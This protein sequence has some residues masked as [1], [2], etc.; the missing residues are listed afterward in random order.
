MGRKFTTSVRTSVTTDGFCVKS[1]KRRALGDMETVSQTV[2]GSITT[3]D[4]NVSE[5]V[6]KTLSNRKLFMDS[7]NVE[8]GKSEL[9]SEVSDIHQVKTTEVI[10]HHPYPNELLE[11]ENRYEDQYLENIDV[12]DD[13]I[14]VEEHPSDW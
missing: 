9:V 5:K 1:G 4:P 13:M 8:L 7:L 2:N 10:G 11:L 14:I 3:H 6:T 12:S